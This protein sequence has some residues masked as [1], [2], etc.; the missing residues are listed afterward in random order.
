ML[1]KNRTPEEIADFCSYDLAEVEAV[2]K[3]L[4][5]LA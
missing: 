3:E 1:L 4:L 5:T 2:E